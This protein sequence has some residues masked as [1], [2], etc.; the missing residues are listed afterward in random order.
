MSWDVAASATAH[1][2]R[3]EDLEVDDTGFDSWG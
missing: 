3:G 2:L 1:P